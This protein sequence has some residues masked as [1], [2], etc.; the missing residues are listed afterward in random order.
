MQLT[1]TSS[2]ITGTPTA[3][4]WVQIHDFAPDDEDKIA[5]RGHLFLIVATENFEA[6]GPEGL[7]PGGE[8][9][10][11]IAGRELISRF[12]EEY[13]GDISQKPFEALKR[14]AEKVSGEFV[15]SFGNIEIASCALVGN[16]IYSAAGGG[17][18][19]VILR[20]GM[21]ATILASTGN[22][23]IS[24]SGYPK[25][26]D[27]LLLGT[28]NFFANVSQGVI[29]ASLESKDLEEATEAFASIVHEKEDSGKMGSVVVKFSEELGGYEKPSPVFENNEKN[30]DL[31]S[32][33]AFFSKF[34]KSLPEKRIYISSNSDEESSQSGKKL[35]LTVGIMLLLILAISIGFGIRQ[36]KIK[37]LQGEYVERLS[38]ANHNL[39]EAKGLVGVDSTKAREL[40]SQSDQIYKEIKELGAK[41]I[42]IVEL[43][44]R[45]ETER[46]N[47]LGEFTST[48]E[49]FLDLSLLSSGFAASDY[50]TSSDVIYILDKNSKKIVSV[51]ID[52]KKSKVIAS[53]DNVGEARDIASYE[54]RAFIL[55]SDGVFEVGNTR[56]RVIEGDWSGEAFVAAYT[57]NLYILDKT[58][59][60]IY[61]HSGSGAGFGT[62]ASWITSGTKVD[63]SDAL[64]FVIDGS[65]YVYFGSGK[66]SK[67][68]LGSPQ[69]F[70]ISG[71]F[72]EVTK[73]DSIYSNDETEHLYL[74]DKEGKR[75]VVTDKKGGYIAQYVGDK[76][77]EAT[78]I[79]VSEKEKK[80]I[81]IA[82]DK[83]L[84]I[85]IKH[86]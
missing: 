57:G 80:I 49:L 66:I 47:I 8:I 29:K 24:A 54:G 13:Y 61:R 77:G 23:I 59:N 76:I 1:T 62:G 43:K 50:S 64:G 67:Y 38:Q 86:L 3:L 55:S 69:N 31:N 65:V 15:S 83:L 30:L 34:G 33:F 11:L 70:A 52:G 7:R 25:T 72:P 20:D 10:E 58:G 22:E 42:K 28:K 5:S 63:F 74:L 17:G 16:V 82:G 21:I 81:L 78:G 60:S 4:G 68:S 9:S 19:V 35:T 12:Q 44:E 27:I 6:S 79:V 51:E 18:Q 71:E 53:Q 41:D 75:I 26:G 46:T 36:K 32:F 45:L 14:S 48:P 2:K 56:E 73:I 85:E 84:S 39:D 37:N 40:F